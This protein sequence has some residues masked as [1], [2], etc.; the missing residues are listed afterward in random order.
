[1]ITSTHRTDVVVAGAGIGGCMLALLLGRAG[2]RV[3]V[4]ERAP[5]LQSRGAEFLKP[6][7]LRVLAR[8]GL[9]DRLLERRV[10]PRSVVRYYHDGDLL[11]HYDYADHTELGYYVIVPYQDI[12]ETIVAACTELPGVEFRFAAPIEKLEG[13]HHA[14]HAVGIAGGEWFEASSFVAACGRESSMSSFVG[15]ETS[16]E[17]SEYDMYTAALPLLRSVVEFNR[18]YFSSSGWFAY[19]YPV[20]DRTRM[21]V[22]SQAPMSDMRAGAVVERIAPFVTESPDALAVLREVPEL[23]LHRVPVSAYQAA[24]YH[25]GNVALLGSAAWS[26]HPMTGQGMSYTMEDACELAQVLIHASAAT[27]PARLADRYAPRHTVHAR[28]IAYGEDLA[29]TYHD[30]E[31][32]EDC[33]DPDLHGGDVRERFAV[34]AAV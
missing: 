32:Y 30:Q 3:V 29:R 12:V 28:L 34:G 9:L 13:D 31:E 19:F 1:M 15:R 10:R 24:S 25:R 27:L 22:G 17:G 16:G 18:L 4:L 26:C 2:R 23:P 21:F 5:S 8:Y 6:R 7:G 20:A 11:R 33:F 14:L